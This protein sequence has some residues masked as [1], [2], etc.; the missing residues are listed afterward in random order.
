VI[1]V[2]GCLDDDGVLALLE[3]RID[4]STLQDVDTHIDDCDACR[5]VVMGAARG[6][7]RGPGALVEGRRIGRYLVIDEIGRGGFGR[8]LRAFDPELE[9]Q[10]AI[11]LLV[12]RRGSNHGGGRGA[13]LEER[14]RSEARA[15]AKLSHPNVVAVYEVGVHGDVV[16]LAME[17]VEGVTLRTWLDAGS[18]SMTEV[19]EVFRAAGAGLA[20]AH[21]A[22]LVHGDFKPANVLLGQGRPRV[23][24]FGLARS[25]A[26][27]DLLTLDGP[28]SLDVS[29]AIG[30]CLVG[31]PAY[32][33]PEQL[34]G[35]AAN[36][37]SDQYAFCV[38]LYEAV[39]GE[40]PFDAATLERLVEQADQRQLSRAPELPGWLWQAIARG[41]DPDPEA[42]HRDMAAL[43][44]ALDSAPASR[45]VRWVAGALGLAA[46]AA[47][48]A[49][50]ASEPAP[51][52]AGD[53]LA[54]DTWS[55]A[56]RTELGDAVRAAAPELEEA[57][58]SS[59]DRNLPH[60][61]EDWAG[62]YRGICLASRDAP[63]PN[64]EARR[65]CLMQQRR[66]V[67]ALLATLT[68]AKRPGLVHAADALA[69]LP[70]PGTC[71]VARAVA[72]P[73]ATQREQLV[74]FGQALA[75]ARAELVT[76][77]FVAAQ[78]TAEELV[79]QA[80]RAAHDPAIGEAELARG[81]AQ[82]RLAQSDEAATATLEALWAARRSG[83]DRLAALAWLQRAAI[84]G[85]RGDHATTEEALSHAAA[86]TSRL[87]DPLLEARLHNGRGVLWTNQ[88]RFAEAREALSRSLAIRR[89]HLGEE[90]LAIARSHTNLGNLARS[91]GDLEAARS[92]HEKARAIDTARLG[93]THPNVARHLHNLAR[94]TLLAGDSER[95]LDL[96]RR[97][98]ALREAGLGANHPDVGVTH[99]SLGLLYA[100]RGDEPSAR[101]HYE[102]AIA[103][104]AVERPDVAAQAR[105]NL[106]ALALRDEPSPATNGPAPTG[107]ALS[108]PAPAPDLVPTPASVPAPSPAPKPK[109]VP[110]PVPAPAP[111]PAPL[112]KPKPAPAPVPTPKPAPPTGPNSYM[113]G[114]AW[115]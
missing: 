5:S 50:I 91:R 69:S 79:A 99:N 18:R 22:G 40:R 89:K 95:A 73:T 71:E 39:L 92:H 102:A 94:I 9:R 12:P 45:R 48:A 67:E 51:C 87:G 52:A 36:A 13:A 23:T 111:A 61:Q 27:D 34:R 57:T 81:E 112:P 70:A 47:L 62:S 31:T 78:T 93:E 33:A 85:T 21:R 75:R 56:R 37:A 108:A 105:A 64:D 76:G 100:S 72:G 114:Q 110:A 60:W 82:W 19:L 20:A 41:L 88:G 113:P 59:L 103:R 24:D 28:R 38:A 26:G 101:Q 30:G 58:L 44:E 74:G 29:L 17:L 77:A 3:G 96:Y 6:V 1:A 109:P 49:A 80:R 106:A 42:R 84:A 4:V 107:P 83:Q 90:H 25:L 35:G 7:A 14:L 8:V 66:E 97:A 54:S 16:F 11:K 2:H 65:A 53:V 98:L 46:A 68:H 86:L 10:V 104:L 15:M 43:L 55:S 115:D 32:M 63:S